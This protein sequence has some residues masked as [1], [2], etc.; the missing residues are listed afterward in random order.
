[1]CLQCLNSIGKERA[2]AVPMLP[3]P[4]LHTLPVLP[5]FG[6]GVANRILQLLLWG[7]SVLTLG[8]FLC[9]KQCHENHPW[10]G[11]DDDPDGA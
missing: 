7:L 9:R 6:L 8:L 11:R 1:M 10:G 3:F 4:V 5:V 2:T